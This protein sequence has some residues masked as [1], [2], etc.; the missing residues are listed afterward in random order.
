MNK[1][2]IKNFSIEARKLLIKMAVTEA[3]LYDITKDRCGAPIQKGTDFEVYR[4]I[5]GTENRIFGDIIKKR[6]NLVKAIS[7]HGFESVM[8]EAAYTWFNRLIAVRFMEVND[9]LP[10]RV[11]VLSSETGSSTPDVVTK[12]LDVDL[13]MNANEVAEVQKAKEDNKYDEAFRLL[14]IKQ[15]NELNKILPGLFETTDDYME[16][17]LKLSYTNDG[18]VRMLVDTVPEEDFD[19]SKEGQVEIIGW[20]YQYY[21]TELKDETFALL[22][23]NV[24]ITKERIPAATQ[25]FTPDWIVRYMV[26]NSLGRLWIEHLR[27]NYSLDEKAIAEE[28]GWN[29]YLPEADQE[30]SVNVKLAEVR[31]SYKAMSPIDIKCIDPCMGSGHILVYMFDV[32]MD[33]YRSAGYSER[34]AAFYILENNISGLD[35]DQRAYQL[36]YFALM[37]K[38]R[39]YNRRFFSGREIE[40]EGRTWIQ[41]PSPDVRAIEES[42]EL[43][44]DIVKQIEMNFPDVFNDSELAS[45]DYIVKTFKDAKEYGSILNVDDEPDNEERQYASV[46]SNLFSLIDGSH[47]FCMGQD[48]NILQRLL[49]TEAFPLIDELMMQACAM[50]QKYDVVA[51]NPPYMG[52]GNMDEKL[53]LYMK[54]N[55]NDSKADICSVFMEKGLSYCKERG[56]MAM[57]TSYTWMF[58]SSFEKLRKKLLLNDSI[59]SLIQ[60]E[61]HAFFEEAFVPICTFVYRK[62][63][64]N[65]SGTYIKLSDFYGSA[66][67]PIKVIEA[68]KNPKCGY[69]FSASANKFFGIPGNQIAYWISDRFANAFEKKLI[70][71]YAVAKKGLSTGDINKYARFWHEV[72]FFKIAFDCSSC[73]ESAQSG[74]KWFPYIKGGAFRR[75]GG[76]REYVVNWEK[77][78]YEVKNFVDSRGKQRS[79]PQNVKFYFKK[80]ITYS[81]ITTYKF[82][83]RYMDKSIFGG[84]GDCIIPQNYKLYNYIFAY[85]NSKV[86]E[87][88]FKIISPTMN[89]EVGHILNLP[90]IVT[91]NSLLFNEISMIV[92]ENVFL[93]NMEWDTYETSWNFQRHPFIETNNQVSIEDAYNSWKDLIREKFRENKKN[94]ERLNQIFIDI[95]D[96]NEELSNEVDEKDVTIRAVDLNLE[97]RK[98]ISYAV[99]CMFGRYSLD[100]EGLIC[101][102]AKIC[103]NEYASYIP[104]NDNIIPIVD[105]EYFDDDI[106]C[107][108]VEFVKIVYGAETLEK[109][110]D[111]IANVFVSNGGN[112]R[113]IIRNYFIKDFFKDHCKFYQKRPIYWLF[114]SGMQNGFKTLI[115]MHRYDRDT[116][117]RI[118]SDYLH[119][120]QNAIEGALKNAEYI[121]SSSTSAVDKAKATKDRDRYIKQLSETR[122]YDQALAHVALQRI[123]IDLDDG[124]KHNYE[125][126]QGIEVASEGTKKQ[127]IDL[128]AKL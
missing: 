38:G 126:F 100:K 124:V 9:Y 108:F 57:M 91:D 18:V 103:L 83:T 54:E 84:G 120:T 25:L 52:N 109:N 64:S 61:Y 86:A 75:W 74:M 44:S 104:D 24:K 7:E 27:A 53:S 79:R 70:S 71:D 89:Y 31:K 3:G 40:K 45:I 90:L 6:A 15:C 35:I 34:D 121:I 36:S 47:P 81:A 88:Y 29:Y 113:E 60:P 76:N 51:T 48:L 20:M 101:T 12:S 112:S 105:N 106:V 67:Q 10:S 14:F 8:E 32:L 28:F 118:R 1:S 19:V 102:D 107:R 80:G 72:N 2:A 128:L 30:E 95:Y 116:I 110:L 123:D 82:S 87:E 69:L 56:W 73:E 125:L 59:S 63:V 23:K 114:D 119:K 66:L 4:T 92:D 43:P 85:L 117:G 42:N 49:L 94:E 5:A 99:G 98:F 111:F 97:I 65:Y 21:N 68:I 77:D 93:S 78:G 55:F 16:L 96:L 122:I 37:M 11:R 17:L 127:A 115:Y 62:D 50:S 39:G 58:L 22:K 46:A 13:N 33:I 26:E 41:Y